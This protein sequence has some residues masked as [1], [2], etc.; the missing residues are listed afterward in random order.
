MRK[1]NRRIDIESAAKF[2]ELR[3]IRS[4]FGDAALQRFGTRY[5]IDSALLHAAMSS[6][7]DRRQRLRRSIDGS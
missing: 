7:Y 3:N 2:Q 1:N 5:L 4:A 6:K